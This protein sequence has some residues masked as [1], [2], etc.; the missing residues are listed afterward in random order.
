MRIPLVLR[1]P[2]PGGGDDREFGKAVWQ[3]R[4]PPQ[5]LAEFSGVL[6]YLRRADQELKRAA[7]PSASPGDD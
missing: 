2:E 3:R 6:A 1:A 7:E 4:A 5:M